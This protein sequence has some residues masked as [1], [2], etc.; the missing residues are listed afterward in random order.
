MPAPLVIPIAARVALLGIVTGT[1]A[2]VGWMIKAL[3]EDD[4]KQRRRRAQEMNKKAQGAR[5]G[6][7][8][9]G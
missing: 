8:N 3:H 5:E 1:I 6:D 9:P 7:E 4:E 2:A